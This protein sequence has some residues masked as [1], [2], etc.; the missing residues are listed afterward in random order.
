MTRKMAYNI[1]LF[2]CR[3]ESIEE[4]D[5]D[6]Y[7]YGFEVL[8][9]SVLE[10]A[11]LLI[12]GMMLNLLL[13]T[14]VF[15]CAFGF[16]RKFTG[17]YHASSKALCVIMSTITCVIN[18]VIS[19]VMSKFT[20]FTIVLGGLGT[21]GICKYAPKAHTNKPLDSDQRIR[22]RVISRVICVIYV[23]GMLLMREW[24]ATLCNVLAITLF[25]VSVLLLGREEGVYEEDS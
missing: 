16:L 13:E 19:D 24:L 18:V 7:T 12:V 25:Q 21:I 22:N 3:N 4:E 1:S 5:I 15:I 2:L 14:V 20:N 10:T 11:L 6:I 23:I 9:D 17:G 8:I